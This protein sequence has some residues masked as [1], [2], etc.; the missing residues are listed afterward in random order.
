MTQSGTFSVN[1]E[2]NF[3]Q[4]L[5]IAQNAEVNW[6]PGEPDDP[7]FDNQLFTDDENDELNA[8]D[9][10]YEVVLGEDENISLFNLV[11]LISPWDIP[12]D[13]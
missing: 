11:I 5:Y 2:A 1:L 6:D 4:D 12:I 10:E 7:S 13:R 9:R 8:N 3:Q